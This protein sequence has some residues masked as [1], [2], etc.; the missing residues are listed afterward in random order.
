MIAPKTRGRAAKHMRGGQRDLELRGQVFALSRGAR[1]L[2]ESGAGGWSGGGGVCVFVCVWGIG[3]QQL[4]VCQAPKG[5]GCSDSLPEWSKGVD[6]SSTSE[7][8][9]GSNPTAVTSAGA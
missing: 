3:A 9:V 8:C 7:S 5:D 2:V 1:C 4:K 6:S